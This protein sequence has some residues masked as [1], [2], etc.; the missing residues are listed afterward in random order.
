MFSKRALSWLG[1]VR[2]TS[3]VRFQRLSQDDPESSENTVPID[4]STH[5][6]RSSSL[7]SQS[8]SYQS[9][10]STHIIKPMDITENMALEMTPLK[11]CDVN[12]TSND[13]DPQTSQ[14]SKRFRWSGFALVAMA[15]LLGVLSLASHYAAERSEP[16]DADLREE[17][18]RPLTIIYD[19]AMYRYRV[20]DNF[21]LLKAN[22]VFNEMIGIKN[23]NEHVLAYGT[24]ARNANGNGWNYLSVQAVDLSGQ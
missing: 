14:K 4:F 3:W 5:Q 9:Y 21:P 20:V 23:V 19:E 13:I 15:A 11:A 7:G 18:R 12:L 24:C 2:M 10:G 22:T 17:K 1:L 6:L 8:F 16:P